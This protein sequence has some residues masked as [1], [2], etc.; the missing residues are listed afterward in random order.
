M[1]WK[2]PLLMICCVALF[3]LVSSPVQAQY[4]APVDSTTAEKV[5]RFTS[6]DSNFQITWPS[7]CKKLRFVTKEPEYFVG[8]EEADV[9]VEMIVCE[10]FDVPDEGCSI[11]ATFGAKNAEGG[12]AGSDEVVARLQA[13]L[14]EYSVTVVRQV[15]VQKKF[16]DGQV[17]EGIDVFG[18]KADGEGQ[19]WVRGLLVYHD[20]FI[21]TAWSAKGDLWANPAYETFFNDFIPNVN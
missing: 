1:P 11:A 18:T 8:E 6:L 2:S 9:T 4:Q 7:G 14:A 10:R 19:F 5:N 3:G 21:L 16:P 17:V 20:I 13:T 12:E 15:P